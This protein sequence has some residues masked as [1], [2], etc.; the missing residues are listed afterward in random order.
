MLFPSKPYHLLIVGAVVLAMLSLFMHRPFFVHI[1]DTYYVI[2][3]ALFILP[4][5]ILLALVW[6]L[7]QIGGRVYLP[8]H[9]MRLHI[10][11]TLI[12]ALVTVVLPAFSGLRYT[13]GIHFRDLDGSILWV[14][15]FLTLCIFSLVLL[16]VIFV[17]Y[18]VGRRLI[19]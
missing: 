19:Y 13:P 7:Y 9:L 1:A 8:L 15:S 16:Q 3:Y 5:A 6:L 4:V 11:A 18:I 12:A 10:P 17:I 2:S 14:S